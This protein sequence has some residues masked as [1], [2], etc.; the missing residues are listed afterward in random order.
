[1]PNHKVSIIIPA[2]NAQATIADALS[3]LLKQSFK[4]WGAIIVDDGSRDR[5]Q[6]IIHSFVRKY[7]TKFSYFYQKNHGPAKARNLG[8]KK[9][10]GRYLG[11]LDAD[12]IYLPRRLEIMVKTLEKNNF[13]WVTTDAF[14]WNPQTGRKK[15][16]YQKF[17]LPP[18]FNLNNLLR[19]NFIFGLPLIKR[20]IYEKVGNLDERLDGVEDY[21]YWLRIFYAGF[22]LKIIKE[23]LVLYRQNKHSLSHQATKLELAK[24]KLFEKLNKNFLLTKMQKNIINGQ[25]R[26]IYFSLA[27]KNL[28]NKAKASI[29][30]HLAGGPKAKLAS[31]ILS[32]PGGQEILKTYLKI[33]NE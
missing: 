29:F 15:R 10:K 14:I 30:F 8:L 3:S 33:K 22:K 9:A 6:E 13:D 19:N 11:F 4:D 1:M 24:L 16:Y 31:L 25:K 12:D 5:T 27:N 26:K 2:F 20:K 28:R 21:D 17:L 23:P 32:L 18:K 7:P